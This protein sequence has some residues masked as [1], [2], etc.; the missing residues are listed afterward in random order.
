MDSHS[1]SQFNPESSPS[2]YPPPPPPPP[3]EGDNSP[4][5]NCPNQRGTEVN[6]HWRSAPEKRYINKR[7]KPS[8]L[9]TQ[10]GNTKAAE[11]TLHVVVP[12]VMALPTY[13]ISVITLHSGFMG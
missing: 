4:I 8:V 7:M 2:A 11:A 9:I 3:P 1:I 12:I 5:F 10:Y 13:F 6:F